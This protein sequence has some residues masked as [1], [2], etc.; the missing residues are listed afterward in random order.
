MKSKLIPCAPNGK[1][2]KNERD[3]LVAERK[4]QSRT[5]RERQT[6]SIWHRAEEAVR[7]GAHAARIGHEKS[8]ALLCGLTQNRP[9]PGRAAPEDREDT[10]AQHKT[11][12]RRKLARDRTEHRDGSNEEQNGCSEIRHEV[13]RTGD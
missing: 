8:L 3:F 2:E 10:E 13:L 1:G 4:T 5:K 12:R 6:K 11:G 9:A 7:L